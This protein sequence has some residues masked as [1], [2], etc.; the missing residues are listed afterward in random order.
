MLIVGIDILISY[1]RCLLRV[2]TCLAI[3]LALANSKGSYQN[4]LH[5]ELELE[6]S[7]GYGLV[8]VQSTYDA[9]EGD[10]DRQWT[11]ECTKLISLV[12]MC[13]I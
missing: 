13:Q 3:S 1:H 6:C 11:W 4:E 10:S 9:P 5:G 7:S 2:M 12:C 8:R